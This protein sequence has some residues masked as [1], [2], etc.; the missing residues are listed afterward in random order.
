[1]FFIIF[2]TR[3]QLYYG[4]TFKVSDLDSYFVEKQKTHEIISTDSFDNTWFYFYG[5]V[6]AFDLEG[7]IYCKHKSW[8]VVGN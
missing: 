1:M 8:A 7:F 4:D 5:N 3:I 6:Y 2:T